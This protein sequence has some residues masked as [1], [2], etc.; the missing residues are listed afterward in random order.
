[1]SRPLFMLLDRPFVICWKRPTFSHCPAFRA[2]EFMVS[3]GSKSIAATN[4]DG[5]KVHLKCSTLLFKAAVTCG[6]DHGSFPGFFS[7]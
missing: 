1:M 4:R 7:G 5:A 3:P 2:A 6:G